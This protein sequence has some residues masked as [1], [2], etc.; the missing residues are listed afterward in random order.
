MP[1]TCKL[2]VNLASAGPRRHSHAEPTAY[3]HFVQTGFLVGLPD[4]PGVLL[5]PRAP[6]RFVM[7]EADA[8]GLGLGPDD[9][10]AGVALCHSEDAPGGW[11]CETLDFAVGDPEDGPR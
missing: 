2:W 11:R 6:S 8:M 1:D 3:L 9:V 5:D 10:S 4:E 7:R